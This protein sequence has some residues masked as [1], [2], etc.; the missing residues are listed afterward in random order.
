MERYFIVVEL[1]YSILG[2]DTSKEGAIKSAKYWIGDKDLEIKDYTG[3]PD[4][5]GIVVAKCSKGLYDLVC[6]VGGD[7]AYRVE[8][9]VFVINELEYEHDLL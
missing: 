1:G 2:F 8:N 4:E 5:E 6:D 3:K 9:G 7:V